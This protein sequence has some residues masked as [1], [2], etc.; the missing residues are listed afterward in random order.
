MNA[1]DLARYDRESKEKWMK[2]Y[3]QIPAKV[4]TVPMTVWVRNTTDLVVG[5]RVKFTQFE[6]GEEQ[7]GYITKLEPVLFIDLC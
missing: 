3:D 5:G 6:N 1:K 4:G 7:T 2:L